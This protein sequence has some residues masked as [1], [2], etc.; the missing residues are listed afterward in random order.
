MHR[1][2][3]LAVGELHRKSFGRI[4]APQSGLVLPES[5][6]QIMRAFTVE[7]AVATGE[8]VEEG[9]AAVYDRAEPA[10]ERSV[11]C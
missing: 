3:L 5:E 10:T 4:R 2:V 9:H 6:T 11:E 8:D 1:V 7:A